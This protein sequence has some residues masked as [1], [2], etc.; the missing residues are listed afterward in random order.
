MVTIRATTTGTIWKVLIAPGDI[1]APGGEVVILESMKM[2]IPVEAE[3][4][5]T[6]A[7][8]LI[9]AGD[10]V[11]QGQPLVEIENG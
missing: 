3:R 6:V 8:V 4:G 1:V 11:Q 9:G 5:G 2:E 10:A 7:R